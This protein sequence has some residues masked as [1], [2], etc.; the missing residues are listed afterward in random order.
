MGKLIKLIDQNDGT[1]AFA[2]ELTAG[3]ANIGKVVLDN[4]DNNI[5]QVATHILHGVVTAGGL[6][7]IVDNT[8][9]LDIDI[10]Q[11]K[12]FKV[13]IGNITY[14]RRILSNLQNSL[15]FEDIFAP[16]SSVCTY[17][18]GIAPDGM[19]DPGEGQIL[20]TVNTPGLAGNEYGMQVT[21]SYINSTSTSASFNENTIFVVLGTSDDGHIAE[22]TIGTGTDGQVFI[23]ADP[24]YMPGEFG[25]ALSVEVVE[26]TGV[27][28][29]MSVAL[30]DTKITVTLGT[31]ADEELDS[32]KNTAA[33]IAA[34]IDLLEPVSAEYSGN[35][36]AALIA[37][38]A[39][40]SLMGGINPTGTGYASDVVS[41]IN[42]IDGIEVNAE[43]IAAGPIFDGYGSF[44]GGL[45]AI[46]VPDGAEYE[47]LDLGGE[48]TS[49]GSTEWNV[50][51]MQEATVNWDGSK[52]TDSVHV[53]LG[54]G[55]EVLITIINSSGQLVPVD[56][57]LEHEVASG[58]YIP[59]MDAAGDP[60]T[61][62]VAA[63]GGKGVFGV[64]Q[65]FPR[66][67]GGR[68][69]LT[70]TS[71]PTN[72]ETTSVQVQEV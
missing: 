7:F 34:A 67:M 5:G 11:G 43:V 37:A 36:S 14:L 26:G 51:L 3:S 62:T 48:A 61:W 64:I 9:D 8:L 53:P 55:K 39:E 18:R 15:R 21:T 23:S 57:T 17:G 10:L 38:E 59:Y 71:A 20:I 24:A 6:D 46:I 69:V 63:S 68:V 35:G 33:L 4:G 16:V 40:Q 22:A 54:S 60:V 49:G 25:N 52:Q 30:D 44:S 50:E 31:D 2:S 45:D 47:V 27:D 32:T 29:A 72:G 66:F 19:G 1:Y 12:V 56:V 13:E 41:A 70:G 28:T 42:G 65:G 58:V